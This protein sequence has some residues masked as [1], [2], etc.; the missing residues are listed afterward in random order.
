MDQGVINKVCVLG[1]IVVCG[2]HKILYQKLMYPVV[3]PNILL[4]FL[5]LYLLVVKFMGPDLFGPYCTVVIL[6]PQILGS[7]LSQLNVL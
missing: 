4:R 6:V 2:V 3:I 7:L 5:N 1:V